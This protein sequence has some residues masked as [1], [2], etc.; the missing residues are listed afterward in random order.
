M[1]INV[2]K[3]VDE[4]LPVV[5]DFFATI[6]QMS[7]L[8][9]GEFNVALSGGTSPVKLYELLASPDFK[10]RI[11]WHKINFFFGDERY[12]S[13]TSPENNAHMVAKALFDPL[14]IP[15]SRIFSVDTT[16]PPHQAARNYSGEVSDHFEDGEARFD[17]ILL[18]LGANAHTAS[19]FPYTSVLDEK[20]ASIEAVYLDQKNGYRIT[21]TAPLINQ[22][23]HIAFLVFGAAKR[24]AV[25]HV[26][27]DTADP[28]KYPAQLIQPVDGDLQWFM[29][30]AAASRLT[31]RTTT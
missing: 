10:E 18:G 9:R 26:L 2:F 8:S 6:A 5:A 3:T 7:I 11:E 20:F 14:H 27:D 13:K 1:K 29:D 28:G 4:L 24:D 25:F 19:L 16:L 17:L 21:M 30:E 31:K 22:A 15:S 23:R 12:V